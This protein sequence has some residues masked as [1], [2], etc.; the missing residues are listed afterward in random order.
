[1]NMENATTSP[2]SI[3]VVDDEPYVCDALKMLLSLDGHRV[4]TASSGSEALEHYG[5]EAFDLVITDYSMPAM[6]GDELAAAIKARNSG[7]RVV[8]ITAYV[9]ALSTTGGL[10]SGVDV[11]VGKPF[12]LDQIRKAIIQALH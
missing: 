6:K 9:E 12:Q 11:L 8:M 4:V 10:P 7:Q 3:L 2:R 1:M 5:K